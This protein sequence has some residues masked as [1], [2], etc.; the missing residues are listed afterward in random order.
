VN[1]FYC[2][3]DE[4]LQEVGVGLQLSFRLFSEK[5]RD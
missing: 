2:L 1:H 3:L 5:W 4:I